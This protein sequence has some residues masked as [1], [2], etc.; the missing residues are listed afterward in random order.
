MQNVVEVSYFQVR[1]RIGIIINWKLLLQVRENGAFEGQ[2]EKAKR[3]VHHFIAVVFKLNV[4]SNCT[5][6][7]YEV[8]K[9]IEWRQKRRACLPLRDLCR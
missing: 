5:K 3:K 7:V 8:E 9:R 2:K 6:I 1:N 4:S